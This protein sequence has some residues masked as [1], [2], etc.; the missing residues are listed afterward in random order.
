[1]FDHTNSQKK[2]P[3]ILGILER[4]A[5]ISEKEPNHPQQVLGIAVKV[6]AIHPFFQEKSGKSR[7]LRR[8]LKNISK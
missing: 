5:S 2:K 7:N 6:R 3:N 4:Y 1:M 8:I